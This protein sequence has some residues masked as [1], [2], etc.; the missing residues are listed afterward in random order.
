[1]IHP[2]VEGFTGSPTT[3]YGSRSA[4]VEVLLSNSSLVIG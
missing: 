3:G 2:N 1:M 4:I